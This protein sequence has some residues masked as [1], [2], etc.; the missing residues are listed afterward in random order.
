MTQ[1][2]PEGYPTPEDYPEPRP[3]RR[4]PWIVLSAFMGALV[5]GLV[6][7]V[8][9]VGS[10]RTIVGM[11]VLPPGESVRTT[12]RTTAPPRGTPS[13][14]PLPNGSQ[15]PLGGP[16]YGPGDK[17]QPISMPTYVPFDFNLPA[18]WG[19]MHTENK[20]LDKRI[21]CM[22]EVNKGGAAGWIGTD[23]CADGCGQ[24]AQDKVR[25]KLPINAQFWKP[26]DD[27]TSY[28][29]VTGTLGNGTRVVRIAMTCAFASASGGTRDTLAV[30]MITGPPET[31]DTLRKI[32]NE[33]RLR[34]PA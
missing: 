7:A 16:T 22:D 34:V 3:P 6:L 17:L 19:C 25:A 33:L 10:H 24:P 21:T 9:I 1:W 20:P 12:D 23:R 18:G 5:V 28:A 15:G 4:V 32:A 13:V 27:V 8:V 30:A 14:I 31:E 26:I 29:R 2:M 11:A